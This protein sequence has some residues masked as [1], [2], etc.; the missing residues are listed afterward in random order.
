M[1]ILALSA[2]AVFVS[3]SVIFGVAVVVRATVLIL[4]YSMT[5]LRIVVEVLRVVLALV[6]AYFWLRGA[7]AIADRY[8]WRAVMLRDQDET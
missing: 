8:F 2:L 6:L 5:E 4:P 1:R 7:K 3:L